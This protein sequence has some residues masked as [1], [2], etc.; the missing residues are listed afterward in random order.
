MPKFNMILKPG[1][2][3]P[4]EFREILKNKFNEKSIDKLKRFGGRIQISLTAPFTDRKEQKKGLLVDKALIERIT[5]SIEIAS[6]V[7]SKMTLKQVREIAKF[8][9]FPISS[10]TTVEEARK[11]LVSYLFSNDT[12]KKISK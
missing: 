5:S 7:L 11:Q 12:W 2:E 6:E 10:K 9:G 3:I 8:V 1:E 4:E